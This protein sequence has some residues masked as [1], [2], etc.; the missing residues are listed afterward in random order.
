[1]AGREDSEMPQFPFTRDGDEGLRLGIRLARDEKSNPARGS[2]GAPRACPPERTG[3]VARLEPE[4]SS[5]GGFQL[6]RSRWSRPR[7]RT[8]FLPRSRSHSAVASA[9]FGES[10]L[11]LIPFVLNVE[12][13]GGKLPPPGGG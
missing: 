3:A 12:K 6:V 2:S 1:M 5:R 4:G 11:P 10:R 8:C 13:M 7:R 9:P